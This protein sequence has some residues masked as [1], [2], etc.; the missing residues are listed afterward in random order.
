MRKPKLKQISDLL[1]VT[2]LVN[3][4]PLELVFLLNHKSSRIF[5]LQH[6]IYLPPHTLLPQMPICPMRFAQKSSSHPT[7]RWPPQQCEAPN[8]SLKAWDGI[9]LST[10]S[11][12]WA[13]HELSVTRNCNEDTGGL[14]AWQLAWSAEGWRKHQ[15]ME[16]W[17]RHRT[18]TRDGGLLSL[19]ADTE[20]SRHGQRSNP[21]FCGSFAFPV[22]GL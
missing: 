16:L 7:Q 5:P 11:P 21:T 13:P 20:D 19:E 12:A 10:M 18:H 17:A 9:L 22:R 2:E 4:R 1:K 15:S 14:A 8:A 3:A 6:P